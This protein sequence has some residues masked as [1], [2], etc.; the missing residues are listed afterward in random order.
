MELKRLS[1]ALT[2]VKAEDDTRTIEGFGSVFNNL[3]SYSDIV[4]PGA[5]TKSIAKRK[6]V[7]LWQHNS[8]QP[9]GV[10]DVMEEQKKGLYVKGRILDTA[11]GGDAYKLVKAGAISGLSIG[12]SA[13][14]WETD[15]E[16]GIRKLTEVE[17]YEISMVTFPANEKA[18]IT[19]VKSDDGTLIDERAFEEFLRDAGFSRK[20]A[21]IIVS[22]G[23]RAIP[24]QR[25]AGA[26]EHNTLSTLF[27]KFKY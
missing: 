10:W 25:D 21:K 16:K 3:D 11:L 2:E 27:N 1:F 12:Y 22:E 9:I 17:L 7:M 8:D 14:K 24:K 20:E 26:E 15:S 6:P 4:M 19:R 13:K 18:Q 23:Y 5:F